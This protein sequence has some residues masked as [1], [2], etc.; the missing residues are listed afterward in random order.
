MRP[1]LTSTALKTGALAV[2]A[3]ALLSPLAGGPPAGGLSG[4]LGGPQAAKIQMVFIEKATGTFPATSGVVI[5]QKNIKY[6]PHLSAVVAGSTV[7]FKTSDAQL[8]NIYLWQEGE[9]LTNT[10]MPPGSPLVSVKLDNPGPV[11]ITCVV[12][13]EM[14][15]WILVLQ[16]PYFA[17]VKE[18]KFAIP[19]LPPGKY[20]V[21]VWGEK[22]DDAG[23]AKTFP[24]EVK[25]GGVSDFAIKL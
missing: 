25:A 14:R 12:H 3:F 2:A 7:Q 1:I 6:T 4:T 15:A 23:L 20:N 5:D 9:T 11:R 19:A 8:H 21:K 24:L 17:E 22:L 10:A 16:N 18:G 13:K